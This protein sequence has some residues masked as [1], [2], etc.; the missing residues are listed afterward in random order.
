MLYSP[1][2]FAALTKQMLY[3]IEGAAGVQSRRGHVVYL[4]KG[5]AVL[6]LLSIRS[7]SIA[8]GHGGPPLE[9]QKALSHSLVKLQAS[10]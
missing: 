2:A 6:V 4:H 10:R 7:K 9:S 5:N 3:F 1:V 8:L